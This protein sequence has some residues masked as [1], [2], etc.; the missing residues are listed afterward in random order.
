MVK[1]RS[2]EEQQALIQ[3][4]QYLF[5]DIKN[6]MIRDEIL[7]NDLQKSK[8]NINFYQSNRA[9]IIKFI[10]PY[11]QYELYENKENKKQNKKY[12]YMEQYL[13]NL[14]LTPTTKVNKIYC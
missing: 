14:F 13:Y 1:F 7:L 11:K 6:K 8:T 9:D 5:N 10:R 4:D 3:N 2:I 12:E